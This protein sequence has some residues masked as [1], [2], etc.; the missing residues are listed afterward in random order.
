[1]ERIGVRMQ[2]QGP[3][4][5]ACFSPDGRW[6]ATGGQDRKPRIWS[7][8]DGTSMRPPLDHE[9]EITALAFSHSGDELL[10]G[11]ADGLVTRWIVPSGAAKGEALRPGGMILS[12]EPSSDGRWILIATSKQ[13]GL[14]DAETGLRASDWLHAAN[15]ARA[16]FSLDEGSALIQTPG[17]VRVWR[18]P[19]KD[20]PPDQALIAL[21]QWAANRHLDESGAALPFHPDTLN[22][23]QEVGRPTLERV[24]PAHVVHVR[25]RRTDGAPAEVEDE[26]PAEP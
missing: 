6:I 19:S 9:T 13:V 25:L 12:I 26:F 4:T 7:G 1:M 8:R 20:R 3:I 5:V 24:V 11:G 23:V 18:L 15:G 10:S 22:Q 14:W 21:A 17:G 2:H 16:R